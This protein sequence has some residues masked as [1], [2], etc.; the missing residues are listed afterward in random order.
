MS[1]RGNHVGKNHGVIGGRGNHIGCPFG[2]DTRGCHEGVTLGVAMWAK[3][4]EL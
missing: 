2:G 4:G 1:I 3:Y